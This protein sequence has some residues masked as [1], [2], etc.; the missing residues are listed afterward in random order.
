MIEDK[1]FDVTITLRLGTN[2]V[3]SPIERDTPI[4]KDDALANFYG[5]GLGLSALLD[6]G[7]YSHSVSEVKVVDLDDDAAEGALTP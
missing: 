3:F 2:V 1:E 7:E 4:T 6:S 5:Y